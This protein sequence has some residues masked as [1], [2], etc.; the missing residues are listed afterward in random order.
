MEKV[1]KFKEKNKDLQR[2]ADEKIKEVLE[3]FQGDETKAMIELMLN[4]STNNII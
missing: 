4:Q 3:I 2:F 1:K